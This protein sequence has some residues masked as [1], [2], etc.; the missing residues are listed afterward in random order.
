MPGRDET[1]NKLTTLMKM[2]Y[3]DFWKVEKY[4]MDILV[5][6]I[7]LV[8]VENGDDFLH[9]C[10]YGTFPFPCSFFFTVATIFFLFFFLASFPPSYPYEQNVFHWGSLYNLSRRYSYS[11]PCALC[12]VCLYSTLLGVYSLNITM[13]NTYTK[14]DDFSVYM[15]VMRTPLEQGEPRTT[16]I[17]GQ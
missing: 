5:L 4:L 16:R 8:W 10:K 12:G 3:T 13:Y 11:A 15:Y 14:R 7:F 1:I 9:T 17:D 6:K 2:Q